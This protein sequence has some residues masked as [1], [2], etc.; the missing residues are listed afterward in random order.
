ME[1][2]SGKQGV[3]H[4]RVHAARAEAVA[5]FDPSEKIAAAFKTLD[6]RRL[7]DNSP[8]REDWPRDFDYITEDLKI[9]GNYIVPGSILSAGLMDFVGQTEGVLRIATRIVFENVRWRLAFLGPHDP[10]QFGISYWSLDGDSWEHL[11]SI[12]HLSLGDS[13]VP[14]IDKSEGDIQELVDAEAREP[15]AHAL[16]HEASQQRGTNPRSAILI[17]LAALEVGIKHYATKCVPDAE[18]LVKEVPSPPIER[19]LR[20]F[21][22]GLPLVDGGS[23]FE[24]PDDETLATIRKGVTIRNEV[25]HKGVKTLKPDTVGQVLST[26][27]RLLWQ[28][29]AA[30]G[31]AWAAEYAVLEDDDNNE[32]LAT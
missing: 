29:D 24:A 19:L 23:A 28:L 27:R 25:T 17:G 1:R 11:P 21:L 20:D 18:W 12:T 26:V 16:W 15:L 30:A 5:E 7:P 9:E 13:I 8:A 3:P 4:A 2:L 14:R 22:P 6:E 31:M 32:I 10:V